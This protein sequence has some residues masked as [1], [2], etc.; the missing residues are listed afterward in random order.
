MTVVFLNGQFVDQQDAAL[1]PLDRGVML[2]DGIF[3]TIRFEEGHLLFHVA[4]FARLGRNAR[5]VEIPWNMPPEELLALCQQ[6][7]D[8]NKLHRGRL[9]ITVTR[10]ELGASPEIG[11]ASGA[12]TVI[13]HATSIN[14]DALESQRQRGWTATVA[15]FPV[16]HQSPLAAVKSTS[17]QANLL[18]RHT[19]RRDGFDEAILLNTDGLLAEGAMTNL[20]VVKDGRVL[21]PPVHDGALPGILRLKLGIICARLGI[22]WAEE[23]IALEQLLDADEAFL[24]NVVVE[25]M[26]LVKVRD[27]RIGSGSPGEVADRL[28]RA[29]RL[30]VDQFLA[31][32]RKG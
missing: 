28:Q 15:P 22:P 27:R 17:Y 30:D 3:E 2:G 11:A 29:H 14:Q 6:V 19:A 1:D 8:A 26:P 23:S 10:G 20:F 18:A 5:I 13:I 16:N 32:M 9:R 31:T 21:T 7:I 25:V 12:P 24:T 4:H